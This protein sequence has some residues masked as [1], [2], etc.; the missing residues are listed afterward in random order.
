MTALEAAAAAMPDRKIEWAD[1]DMMLGDMP[2]ELARVAAFFGAATDRETIR[3]IAEGPLM[4]RYSK[5]L[6]YEYSPALRKQI[7]A[8]SRERNR[9]E[10]QK[11]M[12]W[13]E[14]LA[15]NH[16]MAAEV[17]GANER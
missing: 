14:S 12:R 16:S 6:E 4:K 3:G 1:F 10:L 7:L 15:R 11:G 8:D 13:L 9:D 5:A 17:I 2:S